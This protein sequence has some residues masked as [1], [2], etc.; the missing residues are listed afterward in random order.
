M[1]DNSSDRSEQEPEDKD[2]RDLPR[3]GRRHSLESMHS[4]LSS[5]NE[6]V[7]VQFHFEIVYRSTI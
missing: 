3:T 2:R 6:H 5:G 4:R 1:P 7:L